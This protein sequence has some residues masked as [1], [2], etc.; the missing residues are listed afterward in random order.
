M[1]LFLVQSEKTQEINGM[2]QTGSRPVIKARYSSIDILYEAGTSSSWSVIGQVIDWLQLRVLPVHPQE[3][4][5][6]ASG[7]LSTHLHT[8]AN[9]GAGS[10]LYPIT[11][12][13]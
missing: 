1:N 11:L 9:L 6:F 13:K 8:L 4:C 2:L 3:A 7:V 10:Q 12:L 5:V